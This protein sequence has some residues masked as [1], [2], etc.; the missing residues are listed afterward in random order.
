AATGRMLGVVSDVRTGLPGG[1]DE[2]GGGDAAV[3]ICFGDDD[4]IAVP[5]GAGAAVAEFTDRWRV[6]GAS[7]SKRWEERF[8]EQAYLPLAEEAVAAPLKAANLAPSDL[9]HVVVAG[10]HARAVR[11]VPRACG[12]DPATVADDLTSEVGN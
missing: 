1:A 12:L 5:I 6:P 9:D 8:G 10:S 7:A 2:S 3:A 4:P 11:A